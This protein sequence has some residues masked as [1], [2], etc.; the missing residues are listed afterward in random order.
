MQELQKEE[1]QEEEEGFDIVRKEHKKWETMAQQQREG[2]WGRG[3]K[4][5]GTYFYLNKKTVVTM[6]WIVS[7]SLVI[8]S[9]FSYQNNLFDV[10]RV[11]WW[12]AGGIHSIKENLNH[13]L[14]YYSVLMCACVRVCVPV[15][16]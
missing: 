13:T 15:P 14:A 12:T 1:K 7:H 8:M 3:E 11:I 16:G 10:Y 5:R 9:F 6:S 2:D 4:G